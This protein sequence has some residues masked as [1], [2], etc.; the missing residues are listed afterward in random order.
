MPLSQTHNYPTSDISS[1]YVLLV[2]L[3]VLEY[4]EGILFLTTNR[5]GAVDEAFKSRIHMPLY[6]PW[7][8]EEQ[9][10]K[11]WKS[12]LRRIRNES[13]NVIEFD[14]NDLLRYANTLFQNQANSTG[15]AGRGP[16]WNG[17]QIR[18]AFQSAIAIAEYGTRKGEPARLDVSHFQK[19]AKASD[20][21]DDYLRRTKKGF[22]DADMA[23]NDMMRADTYG[24]QA[25]QSHMAQQQGFSQYDGSPRLPFRRAPKPQMNA[26]YTQQNM[27]PMG[28]PQGYPSMIQPSM[29]YQQVG[30]Y[31][32]T[33]PNMQPYGPPQ[34]QPTAFAAVP[35][36]QQWPNTNPQNPSSLQPPLQ[37]QPGYAVPQTGVQLAQAADQMQQPQSGTPEQQQ[38]GAYQP[39]QSMQGQPMQNPQPQGQGQ[40]VFGT[41]SSSYGYK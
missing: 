41:D 2:F 16:R 35:T 25:N 24:L 19:V 21:F 31:Q 18:N 10:F 32:Q 29:Q 38:T 33:Q 8:N 26:P 3:R 34:Q 23:E 15:A 27:Q 37:Q 12:Q 36:P 7:L 13:K 14:E 11:I 5:V 9:T 30:G 17:R 28:Q 20:A 22:S 40:Q 6:Y 4:Y 1:L 39:H